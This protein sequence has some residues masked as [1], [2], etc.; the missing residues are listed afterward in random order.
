MERNNGNKILNNTIRTISTS[1]TNTN[2]SI[3]YYEI[4]NSFNNYFAKIAIDI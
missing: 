4:A 3:Y 2:V 1:V